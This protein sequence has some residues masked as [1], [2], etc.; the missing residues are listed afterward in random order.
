MSIVNSLAQRNTE[1]IPLELIAAA[2]L[3]VTY[4]DLVGG[5]DIM[6]SIDNQSVCGA[7]TKATSRSRDAQHLSTA[8]HRRFLRLGCRICIEWL[9]SAANPADILSR[10][11]ISDFALASSLGEAQ[12]NVIE[13]AQPTGI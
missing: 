6:F 13:M 2:G 9:P 7:L 12:H 5:R 10:D 3:L 8:W 1:I 4:N 11:K